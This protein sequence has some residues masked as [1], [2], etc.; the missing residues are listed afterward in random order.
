MMPS[1]PTWVWWSVLGVNALAFTA[2]GFDKWRAGRG[3]R[4]IREST[5]LWLVF[6]CGCVGAELGARVFHH[7]T[8]K[9]SFRWRAI[10]LTVVNP[11]WWLVWKEFAR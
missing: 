4:R 7:K 10:A 1:M 2:F 11:L 9:A 6:L 8:R 3:G 5:L